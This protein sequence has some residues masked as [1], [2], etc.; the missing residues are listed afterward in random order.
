MKRELLRR[1]L[2]DDVIRSVQSSVQIRSSSTS[3]RG[4]LGTTTT[5]DEASNTATVSAER[6]ADGSF[7]K[8]AEDLVV[9]FLDISL[10]DAVMYSIIGDCISSC[11]P[12][13]TANSITFRFNL[14]EVLKRM[15]NSQEGGAFFM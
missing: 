4:A 12:M 11:T 7:A 6:D 14:S 8:H 5:G 9:S 2:P 1:F 3:S 15:D 10:I 13:V